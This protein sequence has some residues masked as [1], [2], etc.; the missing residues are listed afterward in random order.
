MSLPLTYWSVRWKGTTLRMQIARSCVRDR[1]NLR[2]MSIWNI[3]LVSM[4]LLQVR[5][6]CVFRALTLGP[7]MFSIIEFG[8]L[9]GIGEMSSL[10]SLVLV[11]HTAGGTCKARRCKCRAQGTR[12]S[13][14]GPEWK[15]LWKN[16]L[17]RCV[18]HFQ[19]SVIAGSIRALT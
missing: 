7:A 2:S 8:P 4:K 9:A 10:P 18:E 6:F 12:T 19:I 16:C 3:R 14:F 1:R 5:S 13:Y 15:L 11:S 17:T